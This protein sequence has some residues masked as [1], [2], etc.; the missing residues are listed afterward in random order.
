MSDNGYTMKEMMREMRETQK[1]DS[2]RLI[3]MLEHAKNVDNHLDE[4][5]SKTATNIE[6]IAKNEKSI[7]HI[8][9]VYTT[10]VAIIGVIWTGITFLVK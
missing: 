2:A 4:L 8:K 6:N 5:N 7:L 1:E 3:S 9:T 10:A